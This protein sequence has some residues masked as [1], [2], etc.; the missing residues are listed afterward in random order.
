MFELCKLLFMLPLQPFA[1]CF[2]GDRDQIYLS[3]HLSGAH[4]AGVVIATDWQQEF[5][6]PA[7]LVK[8]AV[9]CSGIYD[10]KAVRLSS[11]SGYI[12]F[13]D[14]MEQALSPQRHL[15]LINCHL[16][17]VH[18]TLET[19]EFIRQTRDFAAALA[20]AGKPPTLIAAESYHH[21][22]TFETLANPYGV[23]GR[24]VLEQMR[25]VPA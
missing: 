1:N 17:L 21:W 14:Q 12:K 25:L 22:E 3:A 9:L 2:G 4:L 15:E 6:L 19:P 5:G 13:T 16:T 18:G 7:D 11:R 23:L 20:A 10:L 8:G 24:A